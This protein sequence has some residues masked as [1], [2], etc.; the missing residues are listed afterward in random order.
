M[1]KMPVKE[2]KRE[3][4]VEKKI[5][6]IVALIGLLCLFSLVVIGVIKALTNGELIT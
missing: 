5:F 2:A 1:D 3:L 6:I 4:T